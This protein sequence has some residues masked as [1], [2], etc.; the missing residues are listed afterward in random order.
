MI[1]ILD[2]YCRKNIIFLLFHY[3]LRHFILFLRICIFEN[4][5]KSLFVLDEHQ[6][7]FDILDS[8]LFSNF[9]YIKTLEELQKY[10]LLEQFKDVVEKNYDFLKQ[11]LKITEDDE[12]EVSNIEKIVINKSLFKND[13]KEMKHVVKHL[14][15][16]TFGFL[17]NFPIWKMRAHCGDISIYLSRVYSYVRYKKRSNALFP[18]IHRC[19][20]SNAR[21]I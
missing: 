6:Y 13:S 8:G 20:D 9:V 2:A 10:E 3:L 4:I 17:K 18:Y 1:M 5:L 16:R 15:K 21:G 11:N 14:T 7:S 12:S 19:M